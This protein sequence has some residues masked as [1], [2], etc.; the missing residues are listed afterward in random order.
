MNEWNAGAN[1]DDVAESLPLDLRAGEPPQGLMS[2]GGRGM[3]L[4]LFS[5][6]GAMLFVATLGGALSGNWLDVNLDSR[7]IGL[8]VGFAGGAIV[9]TI[10]S[11]QLIRRTLKKLDALE[12]EDRERRLRVRLKSERER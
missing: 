3:Y 5:Q 11:A 10:G 12:R 8:L 2:I 6:I 1:P 4:A 7:P 9:S